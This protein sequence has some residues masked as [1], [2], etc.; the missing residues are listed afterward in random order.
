MPGPGFRHLGVRD[1]HLEERHFIRLR[2]Q[3]R[4][5]VVEYSAS[6]KAAIGIDRRIAP[7]GRNQ[8]VQVLSGVDTPMK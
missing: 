6:R 1:R 3:D 5:V 2:I 8:I 4:H 7:I